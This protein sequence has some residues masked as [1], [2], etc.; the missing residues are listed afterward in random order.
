LDAS[1][2]AAPHG[3]L[4][5]MLPYAIKHVL[6]NDAKLNEKWMNNTEIRALLDTE[7]LR[8][9]LAKFAGNRLGIAL[10]KLPDWLIKPHPATNKK[11]TKR[12][13]VPHYLVNLDRSTYPK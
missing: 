4:M 13:G 2:N 6:P 5:E 10:S 8:S 12:E 11:S 9:A 7:G 1:I 3:Q